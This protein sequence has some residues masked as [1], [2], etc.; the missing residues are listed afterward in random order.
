MRK[1][2]GC[3]GAYVETRQ[4]QLLLCEIEIEAHHTVDNFHELGE[5][6]EEGGLNGEG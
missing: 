5:Q 2:L 4:I 1:S 3:R 6:Y